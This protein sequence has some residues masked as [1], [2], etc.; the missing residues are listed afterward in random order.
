MLKH[1]VHLDIKEGDSI[2]TEMEFTGI[3][4]AYGSEED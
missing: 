2:I 3:L 1:S 4:V